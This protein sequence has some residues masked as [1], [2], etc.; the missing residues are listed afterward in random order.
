MAKVYNWQRGE[1]PLQAGGYMAVKD[2]EYIQQI[3]DLIPAAAEEAQQRL[4]ERL[5]TGKG[6]NL[7]TS[8]R[9]GKIFYW[10][11]YTQYFHEAMNRMARERGLR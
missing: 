3:D 10:S 9:D 2:P 5:A 11:F 4:R 6:R 8:G 1:Q 7:A